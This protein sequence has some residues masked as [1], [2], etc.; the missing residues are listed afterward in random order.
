MEET[1]KPIEND[2]IYE[3]KKLINWKRQ[4]QSLYV[5]E[6]VKFDEETEKKLIE[7]GIITKRQR[8]K[9]CSDYDKYCE[10]IE[11]LDIYDSTKPIEKGLKQKILTLRHR[12]LRSNLDLTDEQIM[13]LRKRSVLE[14][15]DKE[16]QKYEKMYNIARHRIRTLNLESLEK[17]Y[18]R[19]EDFIDDV[20]LRIAESNNKNGKSF[21]IFS[22]E[23]ITVGQKN[24]IIK[25]KN[26]VYDHSEFEP[27]K[28][29]NIEKMKSDLEY[30][31]DREIDI[32]ER[33]NGMKTGRKE[34]VKSIGEKY[35]VSWQRICQIEKF[36]VEKMK[37][38]GR[39]FVSDI[40]DDIY[41][42]I[43]EEKMPSIIEKYVDDTDRDK[44]HSQEK[45]NI[46]KTLVMNLSLDDMCMPQRLAKE[47]E[48]YG[49]KN[50]AE[51]MLFQ[52]SFKKSYVP[53]RDENSKN[54][55]SKYDEKE[56]QR[57]NKIIEKSGLDERITKIKERI[58]KDLNFSLGIYIEND[59]NIPIRD[60]NLSMRSKNA[61]EK[62]NVNTL[63][64]LL[65]IP[66]NEYCRI[67]NLGVKCQKE[68]VDT[69]KNMGIPIDDEEKMDEIKSYRIKIAQLNEQPK[70]E[71]SEFQKI[72]LK[73]LG[74]SIRSMNALSRNEITNIDQIVN[75]KEEEIREL[76]KIG[77]KTAKEI[78]Q[79]VQKM[80]AEN[81]KEQ[82]KNYYQKI[83][84]KS[85]F[86]STFKK[87]TPSEHEQAN[88]NIQLYKA[89]F[90]YYYDQENIINPDLASTIPTI[91]EYLSKSEKNEAKLDVKKIEPNLEHGNSEE[92]LEL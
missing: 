60:M 62:V 11:K 78:Y 1:G 29:L 92:E 45:R 7:Q 21:F 64:D 3:G 25:F 41:V 18:D 53:T 12:Y 73:D 70:K 86:L 17:G 14:M 68:I 26:K 38:C 83:N 15:S 74:L 80:K 72:K 50:V 28:Y 16:N 85:A 42:K 76:R 87:F 40:S 48:N 59:F 37:K 90:N 22:K 67:R 4:I 8:Q 63:Y 56:A 88:E 5:Q 9:K 34:G 47:L 6:L 66:V 13:E 61:L 84:F 54:F 43:L 77:N 39:D 20:K 49:I 91:D 32:I 79:K 36:A 33:M 10:I 69:L 31:S 75:L 46:L 24:G 58:I 89:A 71:K 57:I 30:L 44:L 2:T 52:N 81:Q 35:N 55:F 82:T 27:N 23:P 65:F 19:I 51:V